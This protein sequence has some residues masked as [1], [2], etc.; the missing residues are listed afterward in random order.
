M[1]RCRR[2]VTG[3]GGGGAPAGGVAPGGLAGR[4]GVECRGGGGRSGGGGSRRATGSIAGR[5]LSTDGAPLARARITLVSSALSEARVA[6]SRADG[7]FEFP[8]LPAGS[9]TV[10]ATRSGFASRAYS[11]HSASR[12]TAIAL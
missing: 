4:A 9:Y 1:R 12:G 7:G 8:H 3:I 6:L 11:E 5:A 10:T 2:A